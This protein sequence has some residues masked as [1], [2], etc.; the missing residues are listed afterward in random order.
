MRDTE[1]CDFVTKNS[2]NDGML[3]FD[4]AKEDNPPATPQIRPIEQFWSMLKAKVYEN[5]WSARIGIN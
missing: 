5:N 4:F 3:F 2:S 1:F